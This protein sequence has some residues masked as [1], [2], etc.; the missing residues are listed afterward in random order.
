MYFIYNFYILKPTIKKT[1]IL[2]YNNNEQYY[3][4]TLFLIKVMQLYWAYEIFQKSYQLQSFELLV[5]L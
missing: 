5:Y 4:F 1:V 2:G 3:C